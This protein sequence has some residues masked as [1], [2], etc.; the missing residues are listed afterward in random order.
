MLDLHLIPAKS[1]VLSAIHRFVFYRYFLGQVLAHLYSLS[2]SEGAWQV[3][4]VPGGSL[5]LVATSPG[6]VK[7]SRR[8]LHG[9]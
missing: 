6:E 3:L 9:T 5:D 4:V 1:S 8:W 2:T 7:L